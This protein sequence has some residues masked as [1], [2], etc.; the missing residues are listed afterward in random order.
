MWR[1]LEP[2]DLKISRTKTKYMECNFSSLD[3]SDD[4]S[5]K[6]ENDLVVHCNQ[7]R[8]LGYMVE[9]QGGFNL[10]ITNRTGVG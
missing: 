10:H 9:S 7:F 6:I 8:Y 5:V 1:T 3:D 4:I 2:N